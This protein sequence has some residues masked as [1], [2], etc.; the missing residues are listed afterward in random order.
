MNLYNLY[1]KLYVYYTYLNIIILIYNLYKFKY[2]HSFLVQY[3]SWHSVQTLIK[4][5]VS[6]PFIRPR[7]VT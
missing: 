7:T 1:D 6:L 2:L 3:F 4:D 5:L